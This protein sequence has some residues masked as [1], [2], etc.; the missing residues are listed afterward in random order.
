[1]V[2]HL[3]PRVSVKYHLPD[4]M[5]HDDHWWVLKTH[6]GVTFQPIPVGDM[7]VEELRRL[8]QPI[9]RRKSYRNIG[10]QAAIMKI[11]N[12]ILN[13]AP[14]SKDK[15]K[16]LRA[17]RLPGQSLDASLAQ[18]DLSPKNISKIKHNVFKIRSTQHALELLQSGHSVVPRTEIIQFLIS[19]IRSPKFTSSLLS[20]GVRFS[21]PIRRRMIKASIPYIRS[22][23]DGG[24]LLRHIRENK[25]Y[26]RLVYLK[27]ILKKAIL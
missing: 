14:S 24:L 27:R 9:F 17:L 13:I 2:Y 16:V 23:T 22:G 3:N 12:G 4:F 20:S 5:Q 8:F 11:I 19:N 6:E 18:L 25:I 26:M 15:M 21:L 10:R 1:M 7:S